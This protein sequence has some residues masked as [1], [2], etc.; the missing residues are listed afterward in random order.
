MALFAFDFWKRVDE[1]KGSKTLATIA[2]DTD[3]NYQTLRNQRSENRYPKKEDIRKIASCLNT[4]EE[5]L[6]TGI[7]ENTTTDYLMTGRGAARGE[8]SDVAGYL[9]GNAEAKAIVKAMM[10]NP[11]LTEHLAAILKMM[12]K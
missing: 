12:G 1:L 4:S 9:E 10:D 5:F 11:G 2:K 6:L 3:I 7:Q 8:E